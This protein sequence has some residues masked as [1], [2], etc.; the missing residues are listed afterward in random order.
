[1]S[2]YLIMIRINSTPADLE[3]IPTLSTS[4]AHTLY[5]QLVET[6][7]NDIVTLVEIVKAYEG[8]PHGTRSR[9]SK[10]ASAA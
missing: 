8:K 6:H 7:P 10:P 4:H 5:A 1:M 2:N 9:T 3:I